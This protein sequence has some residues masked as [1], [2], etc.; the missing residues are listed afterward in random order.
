MIKIHEGDSRLCQASE[1]QT[2][3]ISHDTSKAELL[4]DFPS[5]V[6]TYVL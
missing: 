5:L 6:N 1:M 4:S 3:N 2:P